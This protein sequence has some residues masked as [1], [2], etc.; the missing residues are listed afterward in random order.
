MGRG[1]RWQALCAVGATAATLLAGPAAAAARPAPDSFRSA[2]GLHPPPLRVHTYPGRHAPGLFFLAP[3]SS[4][5]EPPVGQPGAL[6]A[7]GAGEPVWFHPAPAGEEITD[8]R[9]QRYRGQPVL[10]W[11]QG[12]IAVP[13]RF[14]NLPVGSPEP[15]AR[16]YVY[17]NRYQP[18]F[19]VSAP[20]GWTADLHEFLITPRNTALFLAARTVPADLTPYGGP[21]HGEL[22]DFAIQEV[23]LPEGKLLY[24]WDLLE[25][26]PLSQAQTKVPKNGIWDPYHANSVQEVGETLVLSVRNTWAVY[27]I[28]RKTGQVVWQV[29]GKGSTF[30]LPPRGRFFWQH[31]ARLHGTSLLS[32]FDDGCCNITAHGL[33]KPEHP[34]RGLVL[35]LNFK[36]H[37]AKVV[38]AY[39][40]RPPLYVPSQGNVQFLAGGNRLIGWGQLP[41]TTELTAKGKL[42]LELALPAPDESYRSFRLPWTGQPNGPVS[43]VVARRGRR[44][45]AFVSWNG[46]TAV[47]SYALYGGPAKGKL[48]RLRVVAKRSFQTTITIYH[49]ARLYQVLALDGKGKVIGRSKL[50]GG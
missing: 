5:S 12:R 39:P 14:T 9:A 38:A 32:L 43:L 25:H 24:Q 21:A 16:F 10:T 22:E 3:F 47:R 13:P 29:G 41:Y 19:T 11:W 15:G 6:I 46:A 50:V 26:I 40:H 48:H 44:L 4:N 23:S 34:A 30:Q 36:T 37:R 42:L 2:P 45:M 18:L 28:S 27:G 31:D 49:R 8:F 17:S 20:A 7:N 33:E 35:S 1:F